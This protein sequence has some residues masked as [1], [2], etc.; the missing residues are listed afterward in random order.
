MFS[1]KMLWSDP[2]WHHSAKTYLCPPHP[3]HGC[4][5]ATRAHP[6]EC[7][8]A[9]LLK[10]G[11]LFLQRKKSSLYH[12]FEVHKTET[13]FLSVSY[14]VVHEDQILLLTQSFKKKVKNWT[15]GV[16]SVVV[17]HLLVTRSHSDMKG[18]L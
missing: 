4:Q 10:T 13:C 14:L 3:D 6:A 8:E 17:L 18:S 16:W 9:A 5:D 12:T 7:A 1:T 11:A 15:F 2:K